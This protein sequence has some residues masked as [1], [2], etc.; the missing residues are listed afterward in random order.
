MFYVCRVGGI[1][2]YTSLENWGVFRL[3]L[4]DGEFLA[5]VA[6]MFVMHLVSTPLSVLLPKGN[7]KE[8][9]PSLLSLHAG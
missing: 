8:D 1:C 7:Q 2:R 3:P 5:T 9:S 4:S 6:C